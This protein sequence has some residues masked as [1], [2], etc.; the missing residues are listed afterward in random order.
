MVLDASALLCLLFREIGAERVAAVIPGARVSTVN[1][2]EVVAKLV[3]RG[4]DGERV[5]SRLQQLPIE[6]V[7]F[8]RAR[9]ERAGLLHAPTRALGLSLGD[10]ACLALAAELGAVAMTTDR[11]WAAFDPRIEIEVV[12]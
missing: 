10:R 7:D 11:A 8:D 2:A 3:D 9:A 4:A 6:L 1:W 12:R 5:R